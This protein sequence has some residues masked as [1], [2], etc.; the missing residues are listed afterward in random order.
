MPITTVK[1]MHEHLQ[2][3]IELEHSTLPPYLC[4]MCTI[5][6]GS[7][8]D[9][10]EIVR[11]VVLE[12]IAHL[13]LCANVLNAVGGSPNIDH[14]RFV[15]EYPIYL[16]DG[17]RDLRVH[18]LKFSKEAIKTFLKLEL[19][20]KVP[21]KSDQRGSRKAGSHRLM[22]MGDRYHTTAEFY[23]AIKNGIRYLVEKHG[24][25]KV[26]RGDPGRQI[27]HDFDGTGGARI[28]P[29][30]DLRTAETALAMIT[31]HA[32]G[33]SHSILDSDRK[34][35]GQRTEVAHYFRFQQIMLG[36]YYNAGDRPGH[37]TGRPLE[38]DWN[39]VY[40]MAPDPKT[41]QYP[42][43]S[44]VR[45]HSERFNR[46]YTQFLRQ[47]HLAFN[48]NRELLAPAVA[49]MFELQYDGLELVVSPFP[50]RQGVT[51]GPCF[52]YADGC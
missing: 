11:G 9:S 41:N 49:G 2:S 5:V 36:R 34:E 50:G 21:A 25:K 10:V 28:V 13:A 33:L 7:N 45:R 4:A 32:E 30:E 12:E 39:S 8:S 51:A 42:R 19:Q 26:F 18:L 23:E 29:V 15:P 6:P 52:E 1:E 20:S 31:P 38:V 47:L 37:P 35:F 16:P 24:E 27:M 43:D 40:N 17:E 3:A 46:L 22:A 44:N 48:G 14:P